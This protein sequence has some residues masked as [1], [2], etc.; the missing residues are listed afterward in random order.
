[1]SLNTKGSEF[2]VQTDETETGSEGLECL[3][4]IKKIKEFYDD[5]FRKIDD[6]LGNDGAEVK[7]VLTWAMF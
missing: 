5:T 4:I 1:M 6:E 7:M 3:R 2:D